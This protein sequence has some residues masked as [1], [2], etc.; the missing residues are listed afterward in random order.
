MLFLFFYKIGEQESRLGPV[1]GV[2]ISDSGEEIGKRYG[3][4]NIVQILYTCVC[5]GKM[6]PVNTV[7]WEDKGECWKG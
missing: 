4:V 3:R 2:G 1:S 7:S 5:N 6:I